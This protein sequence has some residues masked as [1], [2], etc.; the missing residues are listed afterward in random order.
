MVVAGNDAAVIAGLP[1]RVSA[2]TDAEEWAYNDYRATY[3]KYVKQANREV[4]LQARCDALTAQLEAHRTGAVAAAAA[5]PPPMESW[6]VR[7]I[8]RLSS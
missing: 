7:T 2:F 8:K 6:L 5:V 1:L 4:E 3:Q